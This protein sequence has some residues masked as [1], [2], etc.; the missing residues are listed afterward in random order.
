MEGLPVQALGSQEELSGVEKV[1]GQGQGG[2]K[3]RTGWGGCS[4]VS[5]ERWN[6]LL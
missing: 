3:S 2:P 5:C 4:V 1:G 6:C